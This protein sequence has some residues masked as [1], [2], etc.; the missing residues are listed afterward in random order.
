VRWLRG[1]PLAEARWVVIDTETSGLDAARDR[2]LS[3]GA[4]AVRGARIE[5]AE[6]FHRA[7]RQKTPSPPENIVIHGIGADSQLAGDAASEVLSGLSQFV[8]GARPVGFNAAFDEAVVRN[9]AQP[10]GVRFPRRWLDLAALAPVLEPQ[11]AL[12]S[13]DEWLEP[14]GIRAYPRHDALADALATAELLLVLLEKAHGQGCNTDRDVDRLA[15]AAR[16]LR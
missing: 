10:L 2:L 8:N 16:W 11:R 15:G 1:T 14:W 3:V 12:R 4:V 5:L 13:L 9:A 6:S 7:I